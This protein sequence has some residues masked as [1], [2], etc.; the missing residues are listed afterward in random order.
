MNEVPLTADKKMLRWIRLAIILTAVALVLA[1]MLLYKETPYVFTAFMFLGP[2][3]L[4]MAFLL[5]GWVILQE[6]KAGKVL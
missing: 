6:L 5:L 4:A 3:L 2:L 1:L